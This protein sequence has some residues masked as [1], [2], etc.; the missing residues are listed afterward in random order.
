M[1]FEALSRGAAAAT[2]VD[3]NTTALRCIRANAGA[4]GVDSQVSVV[5]TDVG[6]F[7]RSSRAGSRAYAWVF[8]DP[9]YASTLATEALGALAA[10]PLVLAPG[11]VV[12]VE[13]DRRHRPP[14]EV[15]SLLRTDERHYGDTHLSFFSAKPNP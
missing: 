1:A 3:N 10:A 12:V 2:L 5:G 15:E 13:H 6:A 9:P 7:L 14:D 11:A 8:I 4:L